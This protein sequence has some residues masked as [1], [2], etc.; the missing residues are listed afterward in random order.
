MT[1]GPQLNT[2]GNRGRFVRG[3]SLGTSMLLL[4]LIFGGVIRL[5]LQ[6]KTVRADEN[7]QSLRTNGQLTAVIEREDRTY[8]IGEHVRPKLRITNTYN[9]PIQIMFGGDPGHDRLEDIFA[10]EEFGRLKTG[11][12]TM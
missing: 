1:Q 12:W 9:E 5:S 7:P 6:N 4:A 8:L 11:E 10:F 3:L 2:S